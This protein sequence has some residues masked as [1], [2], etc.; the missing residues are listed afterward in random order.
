MVCNFQNGG[1]PQRDFMDEKRRN[2]MEINALFMEKKMPTLVLYSHLWLGLSWKTAFCTLISVIFCLIQEWWST[3]PEHFLG[4]TRFKLIQ[5]DLV[6]IWQ[7]RMLLLRIIV[8]I[9]KNNRSSFLISSLLSWL[10]FLRHYCSLPWPGHTISIIRGLL[11]SLQFQYPH[12]L[13]RWSFICS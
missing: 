5:P 8:N 4:L 10:F 3:K 2:G 13:G 9:C 12:M 1:Q 6:F 7:H 11:W